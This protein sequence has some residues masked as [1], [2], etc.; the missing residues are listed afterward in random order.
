MNTREFL[1]NPSRHFGGSYPQFV[2][3]GGPCT[4]MPDPGL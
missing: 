1:D 3:F 4:V 2:A